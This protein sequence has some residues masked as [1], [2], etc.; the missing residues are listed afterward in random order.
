VKRVRTPLLVLLLLLGAGR[1]LYALTKSP[2]GWTGITHM[3]RSYDQQLPMLGSGD[4][5]EHRPWRLWGPLFFLTFG[6]FTN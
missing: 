6:V 4:N 5:Q 1:F 3:E 2:Q